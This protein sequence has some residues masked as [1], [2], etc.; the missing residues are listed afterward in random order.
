MWLVGLLL[1][2]NIKLDQNEIVNLD[3]KLVNASKVQKDLLL[4][5]SASDLSNKNMS[6]ISI[7]S[8]RPHAV[9]HQSVPHKAVFTPNL[10]SHTYQKKLFLR[11]IRSGKVIKEL[12]SDASLSDFR[13]YYS[14]EVS[15][16]EIIGYF[17]K[18]ILNSVSRSTFF[19][20]AVTSFVASA[21]VLSLAILIPPLFVPLSIVS[22]SLIGVGAAVAVSQASHNKKRASLALQDGLKKSSTIKAI[23][24]KFQEFK[25][26]TSD[27]VEK[28][29]VHLANNEKRTLGSV[30]KLFQPLQ[31]SY[32][33]QKRLES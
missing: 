29:K 26:L 7:Y 16:D 13:R 30:E 20:Y 12:I 19:S 14:T 22:I 18:K 21:G 4:P 2:L 6:D 1:I 10:F 5:K 28:E 31:C 17:R 24:D 32:K 27:G 8:N 23:E 9:Y 15:K 33:M 3:N 25:A 11:N